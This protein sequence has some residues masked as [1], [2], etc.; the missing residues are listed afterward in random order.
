[1]WNYDVYGIQ[2]G[3][4]NISWSGRTQESGIA[5]SVF[6]QQLGHIKVWKIINSTMSSNTYNSTGIS[7]AYSVYIRYRY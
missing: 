4:Y 3:I 6:L 2:A 1:M 5:S 7:F